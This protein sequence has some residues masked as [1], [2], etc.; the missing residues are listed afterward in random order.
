MKAFPIVAVLALVGFA[1]VQ[2]T[3]FEWKGR[4]ERGR[5][6]EIKGVIGSIRALP[7]SGDQVEV[8]AIKD[9]GRRGDPD[10]VT[11]EVV[12]HADGVTICAM[13]PSDRWDEPN[14]CRP[15]RGGRMST[16]DNDTEVEFT[17][18]VPSGVNFVGKTVI[19]DV[20]A[21]SLDGDVV[22][23]TVNGDVDVSTSGFAEGSTVNGSVYATLGRGDWTGV[24]E[25]STVNGSITVELPDGIGAEVTAKT[26]NGGIESDFPV[27][28]RGRFGPRRIT[29]TIGD[30]G[31][32]L[33]L[34]TVNGTIRLRQGR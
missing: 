3:D 32:R 25:F 18:H 2:Q 19:G 4:I 16:R 30:G 20:E 28:I 14:E 5:A 6:I 10:E 22:A 8:T 12:E 29:G 7:A 21:E 11:F 26:V 24:L 34:E 23:R 17:V 9:E 27:T 1:P 13:Y 33:R 15:M 31:R